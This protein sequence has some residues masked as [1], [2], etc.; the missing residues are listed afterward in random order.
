MIKQWFDS[1]RLFFTRFSIERPYLAISPQFRSTLV[2]L[3]GAGLIGFI[4]GHLIFV[5]PNSRSLSLFLSTSAWIG[6]VF[7]LLLKN[8]WG[9]FYLLLQQIVVLIVF[10][11]FLFVVSITL[12]ILFFTPAVITIKIAWIIGCL[13]VAY[14]VWQLIYRVFFMAPTE[15]S[16]YPAMRTAPLLFLFMIINY[17]WWLGVP[18]LRLFR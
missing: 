6:A 12:S 8:P 1:S 10:L 7:I 9:R 2:F 14:I 18:L 11:I 5:N 13:I 16:H 17:M 4:Y 3:W 15:E